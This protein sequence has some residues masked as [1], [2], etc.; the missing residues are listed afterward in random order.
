MTTGIGNAMQGEACRDE[1][2]VAR[3]AKP[4]A[5]TVAQRVGLSA[6]NVLAF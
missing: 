1:L 4:V 5:Q 6:A 3:G 2:H